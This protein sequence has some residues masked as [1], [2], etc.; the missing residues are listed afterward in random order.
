MSK[1]PNCKSSIS[2]FRGLQ[3]LPQEKK[4]YIL[5][6]PRNEYSC[7]SCGIILHNKGNNLL[8]AL[9]V[10]AFPLYFLV[11]RFLYDN[12]VVVGIVVFSLALLFLI[13]SILRVNFEKSN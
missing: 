5:K 9:S 3:R 8:T 4:V 11:T 1:C 2:V 13:L 10:F 6:A 12:K 7:N